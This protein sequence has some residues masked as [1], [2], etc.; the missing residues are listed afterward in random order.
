[1][2]TYSK[3]LELK[4]AGFPQ[5]YMKTDPIMD[6]SFDSTG[7]LHLLH[8]DNDT[9]WW[10]G[11]DYTHSDMKLEDVQK[12][13]VKCPTLS[14]LIDICL[15]RNHDLTFKLDNSKDNILWWAEVWHFGMLIKQSEGSNAEEAVANLYLALHK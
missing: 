7:E 10:I 12:D 9:N 8:N 2:L 11:N 4:N 13:W 15:E 5:E 3:A 14:D 6:W 1:M